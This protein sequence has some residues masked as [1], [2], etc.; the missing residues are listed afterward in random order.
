MKAQPLVSIKTQLLMVMMEI[1][2]EMMNL[3]EKSLLHR[4]LMESMII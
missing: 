4:T 3:Q 1:S 2:M